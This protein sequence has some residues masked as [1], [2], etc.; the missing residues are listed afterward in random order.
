MKNLLLLTCCLCMLHF[1]ASAQTQDNNDGSLGLPGDNLNLYAVM[2]LFQESRTLQQFEKSLNDE[3]S[4]INNF[5]LNGDGQ[6]D[7]ISVVDKVEGGLHTIILKDAISANE[8][9]D[10]AV[11]YVNKDANNQVQI[12]LIGD[13]ALYGKDYIIEPNTEENASANPG[14]SDNGETVVAAPSAWPIIGALFLRSYI[15]WHSP[16]YYGYYPNYWSPWR[17]LYWHSYYGYHSNLNRFYEGNF[18]HTARY[19]DIHFR[20]RYYGGRRSFAN[21][22]IRRN[23]EGFYRSTYSHPEMRREGS[24][25]FNKMHP[26]N[27]NRSGNNRPGIQ[28]HN[29]NQPTRGIGNRPSSG[30]GAIRQATR[31]MNDRP[32]ENRNNSRPDMRRGNEGS[33]PAVN[34]HND[35]Q[36]NRPSGNSNFNRSVIN[37]STAQPSNNQGQHQQGNSPSARPSNNQGQRQQGNS[38]S[39][40][41]SAQPSNNQGQRQQGNSPSARPSAQPSAQPAAKSEARPAAAR[42]R[43]PANERDS[44]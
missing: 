2:N 5:D 8:T 16:W 4:R 41:P 40:R 34:Q 15:A 35:N 29:A 10:V 19:S 22:V 33:R 31:T 26:G 43:K 24:D 27:M 3:N 9:Q 36:P 23:N 39:A 6:I 14:Y 38:P 7:Y 12:Q 28:Q 37:R 1:G 25:R 44:R 30:S 21:S 13:E 42:E 32:S 11:F 18:R 20:D 17:P